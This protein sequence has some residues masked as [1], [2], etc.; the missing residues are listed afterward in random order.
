V[1]GRRRRRPIVEG[2]LA[3]RLAYRREIPSNYYDL[4]GQNGNKQHLTNNALSGGHFVRGSLRWTPSDDLTTDLIFSYSID[5]DDGGTPRPL[6][7]YPTFNA[8]AG[9][10]TIFFGGV[11]PTG[12]SPNP[13]DP[14]EIS[15]NR[16]QF[17]KYKTFWG[18]AIV[19]WDVASHIVKLNANYQYWDYAIDRDQDFTDL[20]AQRLVLLD[21]HKTWSGEATIRSDYEDS[22]FS[23]LFGANYQDDSAPKTQ[24]PI[25]H[26]QAQAELANFAV[27]DV[28][29][30]TTTTPNTTPICGGPCV[31]TPGD[32]DHPYIFFDGDTDTKTAGVFADGGIDITEQLR[33]QAGVR[34]SWTERIMR[35]K[36]WLDILLEPLDLGVDTA[37]FNAAI[38]PFLQF[39]VGPSASISNTAFQ[40]RINGTRK[41]KTWDSVTGRARLEWRPADDQLFYAGYSRGERHGG[42]NWFQ[43]A[44][45]DSETINA[46]ELGAKNSLL[47]GRLL[48]NSTFF[49]YDFENR[50]ITEVQNNVTT[51]VNAPAASIYGIELQTIW[52]VT[53]Q[54]TLTANAGWLHT[55]ITEDFLSQDNTTSASNPNNFCPG[56]PAGGRHGPGPTCTGAPL[57][58]LK[59]NVLPRSPKF[60]LSA[61][62]EYRFEMAS[63]VLTPRLDFAYRGAVY[64]RQ[65]EN[66]LDRQAGYTR[67]DVR[68]RYDL[69]DTPIWF[70]AYVQNLEDNRKIKTQLETQLN[71]ARYYW[72]AAPRT[73]GVRLGFKF[74]GATAGELW[75]L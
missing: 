71:W 26:Y 44:P 17:Q 39:Q 19:E 23:W 7:P 6:G 21:K 59:G 37:T 32:P 53:D 38:L 67:T 30:F 42:F 46:Y 62:A 43:A 12:A 58:N 27:F 49:Y 41:E 2:T 5:R 13:D 47:D 54:L 16:E 35:D 74:T 9:Q 11:N 51:T 57:Q 65:Y 63:G 18:Q 10:S 34:Y 68:V 55:E 72:L 24:V 29:T 69:A 3:A 73:F 70:E 45:F 50:F 28:L 61:S 14:N 22:I 31:F 8:A 56:N 52:A 60:N 40:L 25:W 75:P 64:Y 33:F 36:G 15:A 20:D 66:P 4:S 1:G 48:V